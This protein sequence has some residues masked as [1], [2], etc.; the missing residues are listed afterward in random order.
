MERYK[1]E[2]L[3]GFLPSDSPELH[4]LAR[5]RLFD[6]NPKD[7]EVVL[8]ELEDSSAACDRLK[9]DGTF[10][11]TA[12]NAFWPTLAQAGMSDPEISNV[13]DQLGRN[14]EGALVSYLALLG[15]L[16]DAIHDDVIRRYRAVD[17]EKATDLYR[18]LLQGLDSISEGVPSRTIPLFT[19]NYDTAAEHA[20]EGLHLG[21]VDGFKGVA[22]RRWSSSEYLDYE[23]DPA[24]TTVVLVKLHGSVRLGRNDKGAHRVAGRE[25]PRSTA[26]SARGA[27]PDTWLETPR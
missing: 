23:E 16:T 2:G 21:L 25:R 24:S 20:V 7:I 27:L 19:L 3:S 1:N 17:P 6:R 10:V 8:Q 9:A 5:H 13:A 15:Q 4:E 11:P 12:A 18:P 26:A 22:G 14:L